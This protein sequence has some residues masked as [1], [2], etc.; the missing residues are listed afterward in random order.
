MK[1]FIENT[2]A[3]VT[4][5]VQESGELAI[6]HVINK[7]KSRPLVF[8]VQDAGL[9]L[10]ALRKVD[11]TEWPDAARLSCKGLVGRDILQAQ[12]AEEVEVDVRQQLVMVMEP[13][14]QGDT[15][16]KGER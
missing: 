16:G 4:R 8:D 5:I 13:G 3:G 9:I 2:R 10:Q 11:W 15:L 1:E 12:R 7:K 6:Q 14:S